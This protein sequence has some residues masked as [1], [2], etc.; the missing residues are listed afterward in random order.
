MLKT[1]KPRPESP[2]GAFFSLVA[3]FSRFVLLSRFPAVLKK[4]EQ[5]YEPCNLCNYALDV[6]KAISRAYLTLRI[7]GEADRE[8]ACARLTLFVAARSVLT[9]ALKLLGM[10]PLERM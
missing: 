8:V 3:G 6:A 1:E 9:I 2:V 7:L 4:I 5:D 10:R